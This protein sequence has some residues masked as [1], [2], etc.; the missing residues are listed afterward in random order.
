MMKIGLGSNLRV[1]NGNAA[2]P[3]G[4]VPNVLPEQFSLLFARLFGNGFYSMGWNFW[5]AKEDE[6]ENWTIRHVA[7]S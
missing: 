7:C 3:C 6:T 2:L 1:Q 5:H 4:L